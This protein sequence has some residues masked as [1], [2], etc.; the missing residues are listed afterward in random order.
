MPFTGFATYDDT[1]TIKQD[2]V[3]LIMIL[4]SRTPIL[5]AVNMG[6]N[7][8]ENTIHYRNEESESPGTITNSTAIASAS[9]ATA[10]QINATG[11]RLQVG[12]ILE[13]LGASSLTYR[14]HVQIASVVGTNS[15]VVTRG[16]GS[17][18]PSSI[19][20]GGS[21][22]LLSNAALEGSDFEQSDITRPR[23]QKQNTVQLFRKPISVSTTRRRV[24]QHGISD[25]YDKQKGNRLLE[26]MRDL[27]QALI[28][29]IDSQTIGS[30]SVYRTMGG[31]WER[32]T[33]NVATFATVSASAIDNLLIKPAVE[34][35]G[36]DVDMI[37][38][39][40][41]WKVELDALQDGRVRTNVFD[42][43]FGHVVSQYLS[44]LVDNPLKVISSNQMYAKS[45]IVTSS[46]R[47][48]TVPLQDG[49]FEH[50]QLAQ[51]GSA[52]KGMI[53]GE[54]TSEIWLEDAMAR[55][56]SS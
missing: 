43:T 4:R 47:V 35:N 14:E 8:A 32:I 36:W 34:K 16:V 40:P 51:T 18:G 31:I 24:S 7:P 54:Y 20:A 41:T 21:L 42:E 3:D 5:N 1:A 53:E 49:M 30:D 27:E 26:C 52:I 44:G 46:R 13:F 39:D 19:A 29:G 2:I 25:E 48:K 55:A 15:I 17:V 6:D 45:M 37:F 9:A 33:T 56:Y 28:K 38:I 22:T 50:T 12:D 10:F 11:G 23:S